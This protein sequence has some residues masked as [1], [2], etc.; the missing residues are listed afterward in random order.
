MN[1]GLAESVEDGGYVVLIGKIA[2]VR[3]FNAFLDTGDPSL[4]P[5]KRATVRQGIFNDLPAG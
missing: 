2:P 4:L 1:S 5:G 3:I